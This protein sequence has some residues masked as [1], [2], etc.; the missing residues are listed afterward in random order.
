VNRL[1][2]VFPLPVRTPER[3]LQR[4][5]DDVGRNRVARK[6]HKKTWQRKQKKVMYE[7]P[8]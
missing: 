7:A 1:H 3:A 8:L 4:S 5:D 6:A 2:A